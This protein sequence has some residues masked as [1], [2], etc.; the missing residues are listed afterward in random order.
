ME[1]SYEPCISSL[2]ISGV[3][4]TSLAGGWHLQCSDHMSKS[5]SRKLEVQGMQTDR[6]E[7]GRLSRQVSLRGI[8]VPMEERHIHT[9]FQEKPIRLEGVVIKAS[10]GARP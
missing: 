6:R 3:A 4:P 9:L 8:Q 2:Q 10:A 5:M 1:L 7:S